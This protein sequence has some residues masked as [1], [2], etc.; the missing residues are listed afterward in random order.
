[1]IVYVV[2]GAT[3]SGRLHRYLMFVYFH[4]NGN[5]KQNLHL[6]HQIVCEESVIAQCGLKIHHFRAKSMKVVSTGCSVRVN[7]I[8][9][10]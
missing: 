5:T 6:A 7:E 2:D 9:S 10:I 1:M 4:S 8:S 3:T